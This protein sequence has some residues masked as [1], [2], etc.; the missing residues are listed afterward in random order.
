MRRS[1][2]HPASNWLAERAVQTIKRGL[3]KM[4]GDLETRIFEFRGRYRIT[5]Q[6]TTGESPAQMFMSKTPRVSL[7]LFLPE[8]ENRV[9]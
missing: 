1:P 8:R 4:G 5:P 2:F 7:D 6:T 9:L 3:K